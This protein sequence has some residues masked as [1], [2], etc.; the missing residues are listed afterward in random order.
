MVAALPSSGCTAVIVG[1]VGY[2]RCGATYYEP[3]YQ[4]D[5]VQYVVVS[6][7]Q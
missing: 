1:G 6:P 3:S 5:G 2:Q 7:P 4:G